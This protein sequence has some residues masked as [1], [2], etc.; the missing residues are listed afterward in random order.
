[1]ST[2]IILI[3][4]I[5]A[6]AGIGCSSSDRSSSPSPST[7]ASS[8]SSNSHGGDDACV[9]TQ[10]IESR[11]PENTEGGPPSAA[12]HS[13]FVNADRSIWML[14]VVRIAGTPTKTA[15]F[16]LAR[17]KLEITGRRLDGD[18]PPLA[19]RTSPTGDEYRHMFQPST[20]TFPTEGCWEITAKAAG[21]EARFIVKVQPKSATTPQ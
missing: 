1:M 14:D 19:A 2:K 17:T 7:Q 8:V 5:S 11:S 13:W 3:G 18:A 15:W 12:V 9:L 4:M 6:L 21:K 16:R 10:S 20:M